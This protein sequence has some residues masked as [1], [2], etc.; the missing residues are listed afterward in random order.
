MVG[1]DR[2]KSGKVAQADLKKN[3]I[4]IAGLNLYKKHKKP[5]QQGAKG[6][7]ISI[8]RMIPASNIQ[9]LCNSC[10]QPT[11]I[12]FRIEGSNKVRFC[13]KCKVTVWSD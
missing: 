2:G 11:R 6:E 12:G 13:K 4:L 3:A 1:K 10:E 5:T 8:S 9:L 7:T